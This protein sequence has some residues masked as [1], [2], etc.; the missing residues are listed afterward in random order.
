MKRMTTTEL[1]LNEIIKA[2]L[3][4]LGGGIGVAWFNNYLTKKKAKKEIVEKEILLDSLKAIN[5]MHQ[6]MLDVI[7]NTPADRFLILRGHDSG[8]V[9]NPMHPY[10]AQAL[11]QKIKIDNKESHEH[12]LRQYDDVKVDGAYVAMVVELITKG[13]VKLVV[14]EMPD[15]FLKRVYLA[16]GIKYSELYFLK[17][18]KSSNIYYCYIATEQENERFE[19]SKY[20]YEIEIAVN[21]IRNI[22]ESL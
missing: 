19:A 20:R 8:N 11:W 21:H 7:D 12:L 16:E 18:E 10:Y 2:V 3:G 17:Q 1:D 14:E 15:S 5:N 6:Y 22:F 13:F 9:P 4:F